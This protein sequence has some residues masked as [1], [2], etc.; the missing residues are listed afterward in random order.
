MS[1]DEV[2]KEESEQRKAEKARAKKIYAR[3]SGE[4]NEMIKEVEKGQF[5]FI[6]LAGRQREGTGLSSIRPPINDSI[7]YGDL[8]G[9]FSES[10]EKNH[11]FV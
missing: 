5:E 4:D 1:P 9:N 11:Q 8:S 10:L 3:T 7:K 6:G 2:K